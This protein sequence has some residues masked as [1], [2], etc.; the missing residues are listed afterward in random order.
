M[1]TVGRNSM[2]SH[3]L[4]LDAEDVVGRIRELAP[5]GV[6]RVVEVSLSD[7]VELDAGSSG[8]AG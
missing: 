6:D 5:D 8:R 4:P 2:S 7:N 1:S 3:V